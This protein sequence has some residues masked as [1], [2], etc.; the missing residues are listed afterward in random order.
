M[1]SYKTTVYV[2]FF[3][4]LFFSCISTV[5][6]DYEPN[7]SYSSLAFAYQ[8][9]KFSDPIC[10]GGECHE[11]I[12][13]P[14]GVF[15]RQI[16]PNIAFGVSGSY[17]QSSGNSSTIKS[18][19]SSF[20]VQGVAGLGRQFDM[21]ASVA[22]LSSTTQLCSSV[23]SNCVSTNELGTDFGI[24][25]KLFLTNSRSVSITFSY[26]ALAYQKSSNQSVV[27]LSLVTILAEHHRLALSVDRVRDTSGNQVSGGVGIGYGYMVF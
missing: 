19:S 23:P 22:T 15:S 10:V 5:F 6:A 26:D 2:F 27:A 9:I 8:S 17:L 13:G 4:V 3:L 25:G 1:L 21:G 24:F 14:S 16:I 18:T 20:F 7:D 11:G 12:S